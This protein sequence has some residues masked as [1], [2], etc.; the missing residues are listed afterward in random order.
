[1]V[2]RRQIDLDALVTDRFPLAEVSGAF[3]TAA[4]R[5]GLKTVVLP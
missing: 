2:E 1:M 4:S 5:E 3:T